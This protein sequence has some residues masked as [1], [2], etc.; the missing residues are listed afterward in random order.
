MIQFLRITFLKMDYF[1]IG[2][3]ESVHW[4][5]ISGDQIWKNS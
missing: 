4:W 2:Y 3:C 1:Y 5:E